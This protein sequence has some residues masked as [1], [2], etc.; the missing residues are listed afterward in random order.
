MPL[1]LTRNEL[2]KVM[3]GEAI[4]VTRYYGAGCPHSPGDEL[5]LS[6]G[7]DPQTGKP[8]IVAKTEVVSVRPF[9]LRERT[10]NT[11]EA[12][13]EA[14]KEGW[15]SPA[16]WHG[17]FERLYGEL[18]ETAVLHRLQLRMKARVEQVADVGVSHPMLA[19]K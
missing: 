2:A 18:P 17:H 16:E 13:E 14:R 1:D 6:F 4:G 12:R 9:E 7:T 10:E 5:L 11:P 8:A 3:A 19:N 15:A